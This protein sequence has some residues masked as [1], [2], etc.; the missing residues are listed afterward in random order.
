MKFYDKYEELPKIISTNLNERN[1]Y[2]NDLYI[3][4]EKNIIK[5]KKLKGDFLDSIKENIDYKLS[6]DKVIIKYMREKYLC[7]N[8]IIRTLNIW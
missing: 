1:Y 6:V 3:I 5:F 4:N 2:V 7:Y 8:L